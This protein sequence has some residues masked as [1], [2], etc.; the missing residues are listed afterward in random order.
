MLYVWLPPLLRRRHH[1]VP[2]CF[3]SFL[4]SF[5]PSSSP[6]PSIAFLS[7]RQA[8]ERESYLGTCC[9]R[10]E[11][12]FKARMICAFLSPSPSPSPSSSPP[13]LSFFPPF[14]SPFSSPLSPSSSPDS[15]SSSLSPSV[16]LSHLSLPPS[17]LPSVSLHDPHSHTSPKLYICSP[18]GPPLPPG[19]GLPLGTR[20][21]GTWTLP[22]RGCW[23]TQGWWGGTGPKFGFPLPASDV[24]SC[25][26]YSLVAANTSSLVLCIHLRGLV[27]WPLCGAAR[28]WTY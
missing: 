26:G 11:S 2:S 5:A 27:C 15:P 4:P 8:M 6:H 12:A 10:W 17:F 7:H 25:S 3:P 23:L 24:K 22:G 20:R 28:E 9:I 1:T 21:G 13:F 18:S 14:P 19:P 16:S